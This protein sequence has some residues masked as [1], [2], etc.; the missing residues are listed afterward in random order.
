MKTCKVFFTSM[1]LLFL[2][3]MTS[4]NND[5]ISIEEFS[6]DSLPENR[7]A[8]TMPSE[9]AKHEGTWLQWP[10]KYTYGQQIPNRYDQIWIDMTQA[11][12]TG[13]MVHIVAYDEI[14][15]NRITQLLLNAN[16]DMNQIDFLIKK[17]ED[18][19]VRDNGPIFVRDENNDLKITNWEFNG[20][21]QKADYFNDNQIPI[22]VSN[23]NGISKVDV[24]MVL[25]GGAIEVDGEGTFMATK[26]SILNSNRNPGLTQAQA[27]I[28]FKHYLGVTNFIWLE[29]IAGLDIT[30]MHIDGMARFVGNHTI[31][32]VSRA[33]VEAF[34]EEVMIRDHNTL[35]SAKNANGES[36]N[37]VELPT[38]PNSEGS[39]LN[40]YIGNEVVL[41]PNYNEATDSQANAI[42]Q[43]LYPNRQVIGIIVSEL[44]IDGGAI[45]CVTQQ[46]PE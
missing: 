20:W 19:W 6:T 16:V 35:T 34:G 31:A 24:D 46:Q 36:Y 33:D 43:N 40:Y 14:E 2:I 28:F 18:V 44:W 39:Y 12:H 23:A 17:T 30:D 37:I 15:K 5:D 11:L 9:E 45:H 4:C 38:S 42:I 25:E 29:G 1:S 26:S 22:H 21:G 8:F 32:T 41:V 3:I 10:H 27:E 7:I 13:E